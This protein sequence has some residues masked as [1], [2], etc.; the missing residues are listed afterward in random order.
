MIMLRR[1]GPAGEGTS[2]FHLGDLVQH[3]RYG[4]RGVIVSLDPVCRADEE[5]YGSKQT[6]PSRD[7]PWYHVLVDESLHV[8][9]AAE[10]NLMRD[11]VEAPVHHP[12]VEVYFKGF[13]D[14]RYLR[15]GRVWE[16]WK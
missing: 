13:A 5:W 9:Y 12:L 16:G 14:G 2:R 6:Q 11:V 1:S 8:T 7:Q 3:K 10:E 4:Y 15:N